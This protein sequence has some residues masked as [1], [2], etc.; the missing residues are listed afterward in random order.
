[1]SHTAVTFPEQSQ[2]ENETD[3]NKHVDRVAA[4]VEFFEVSKHGIFR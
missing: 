1:M 4:K 3:A 2:R